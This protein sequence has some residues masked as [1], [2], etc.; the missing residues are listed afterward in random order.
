MSSSSNKFGKGQELK[1]WFACGGKGKV[2]VGCKFFK[3]A[4]A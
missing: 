4:I 1:K 3:N 2:S